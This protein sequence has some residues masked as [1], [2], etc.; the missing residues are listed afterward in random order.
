MSW[1]GREGADTED[2]SQREDPRPRGP[3]SA[4]TWAGTA[5]RALE[6]GLGSHELGAS[7]STPTMLEPGRRRAGLDRA[8]WARTL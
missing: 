1:G 3:R 7:T 2:G 4:R 6:R 8:R 5:L